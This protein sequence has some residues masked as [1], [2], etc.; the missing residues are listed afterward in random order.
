MNK[1]VCIILKIIFHILVISYI[2]LSDFTQYDNIQVH[3][4]CYKCHY[5]VLF[6][7]QVI[8]HCIYV[9]HLL[10]PFS[11]NGHLGCFHAL[12]IVNNAAMNIEVHV[13]L[14]N[15]G[16]EYM[17][18]SRIA[19]AYS[20]S[21][22]RFFRKLHTALHSG[23]TNLHS[24]Q[25]CSRVPFSPHPLRHLLFADFLMIAFLFL[26]FFFCLIRAAPAAYGGSQA[27]V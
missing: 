18:R 2:C 1:F 15:Y 17:P 13:S 5:F 19:G 16:F 26:F 20:N 7:G 25:Q 11:V 14:S 10:Y 8:F 22:F 3:P 9:L 27:R 12:A 6:C 24:H 23:C 21:I 4:C